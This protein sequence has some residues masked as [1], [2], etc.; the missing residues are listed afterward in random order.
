V[1]WIGSASRIAERLANCQLFTNHAL[2]L[3]GGGAVIFK[4]S[5]QNKV[6]IDGLR[7][8]MLDD[9]VSSVG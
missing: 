5:R 4:N 8:G 7:Y 3:N 1:Y 6:A 2:V 9:R